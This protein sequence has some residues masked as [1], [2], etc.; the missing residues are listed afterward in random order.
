MIILPLSKWRRAVPSQFLLEQGA[1]IESMFVS[2]IHI[3][4]ALL[5]PYFT[6]LAT[7]HINSFK[8]IFTHPHTNTLDSNP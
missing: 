7:D 8:S 5:T 3:G 1:A 4:N 2:G 6:Y